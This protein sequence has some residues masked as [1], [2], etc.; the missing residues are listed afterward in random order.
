MGD[1]SEASR[2]ASSA[3][4]RCRPSRNGRRSRKVGRQLR[5]T[6]RGSRERAGGGTLGV[7]T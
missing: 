6:L 1:G 3:L 5:G 2:S 4:S 7:R